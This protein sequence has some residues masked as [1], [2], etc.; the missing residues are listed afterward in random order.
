MSFGPRVA[1]PRRFRWFPAV[2]GSIENA[3]DYATDRDDA[4]RRLLDRAYELADTQLEGINEAALELA[5]LAGE[6]GRVI[7]HAVRIM[8]ERVRTEPSHANKQA[9]SLVRRGV[10]LGMFRWTWDDT[11]PVP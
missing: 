6:D 3:E 1:T 4:V 11:E 2:R 9:A 10:E 8:S 5:D 7:E